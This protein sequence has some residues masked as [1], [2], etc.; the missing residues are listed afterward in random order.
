MKAKRA[1]TKKRPPT[2]RFIQLEYRAVSRTLSRI[3]AQG[4]TLENALKTLSF[5]TQ[6][7]YKSNG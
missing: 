3:Q 5:M 4:R 6:S 1:P 2:E 7:L